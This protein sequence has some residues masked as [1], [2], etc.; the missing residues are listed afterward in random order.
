MDTFWLAR[1]WKPTID[2]ES[3]PYKKPSLLVGPPTF[4]SK[5]GR[6]IEMLTDVKEVQL[7]QIDLQDLTQ[8]LTRCPHDPVAWLQRAEVLLSLGFPELAVG[9]A[10]KALLL[11]R[12]SRRSEDRL[13]ASINHHLGINAPISLTNAEVQRSATEQGVLLTLG[14]GLLFANCLQDSLEYAQRAFLSYPKNANLRSLLTKA[15]R[16]H[17]Q[18]QWESMEDEN[19]DDMDAL[20]EDEYRRSGHTLLQSYPWMDPELFSRGADV[21]AS[22]QRR[23]LRAS[24]SQCSLERSSVRAGMPL[25]DRSEKFSEVFGVMAAEDLGLHEMLLIDHTAASAVD[26]PAS[27]CSCCCG[28]LTADFLALSCCSALCCSKLCA[29]LALRTYHLAVCGKDLSK[30]EKAYKKG[31][32]TAKTAADEL[33]ILR[34]VAGAVQHSALHPLHTPFVKQ[35]TAMYDGKKHQPFDFKR[36]IIGTFEM[37]TCLGVDIF[38]DHNFDTWVLQTL[39]IRIGNNAREYSVGG[40]AHVAINPLFS[41]FNHSCDP[42]VKWENDTVSHSSSIRMHTLRP[43]SEGEELFINYQE[44]LSGEPYLKRRAVLKEWLGFDCQCTRCRDDEAAD[45]WRKRRK[46][47]GVFSLHS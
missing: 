25:G 10:Y 16:A 14:Q 8:R 22:T 39:R 28:T 29:D 6:G 12:K 24:R 42:N 7:F 17:D 40:H 23:F 9:D 15:Q 44:D 37:L 30:F 46:L 41:F 36:N 20:E 18:D 27:R 33:L 38:A 45:Q 35:L 11:I 21:T 3:V 43:V 4:F 32:A 26:D 47:A 13:A 34:V 1:D 5:L 19:L 31:M 2:A